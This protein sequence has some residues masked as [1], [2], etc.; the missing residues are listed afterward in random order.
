VRREDA[1]LVLKFSRTS[2]LEGA[3]A[4][5]RG[6][7]FIVHWNDRTLQADAYVRFE[8][9]FDG[10]VDRMTLR[11]ISPATDFSF[12]FQDL[13]FRKIESKALIRGTR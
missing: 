6:N 12:D 5:H 4:P 13:D 1:G 9:G 8:Q 10:G 11:A 2:R 7:I 3:L